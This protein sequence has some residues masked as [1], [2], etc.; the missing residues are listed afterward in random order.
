MLMDWRMIGSIPFA[1]TLSPYQKSV[2]RVNVQAVRTFLGN[3]AK[4]A[5]N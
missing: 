1:M 2:I 5:K 4:Q 3:P